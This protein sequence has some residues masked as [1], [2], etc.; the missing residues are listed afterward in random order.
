L[1]YQPG[2]A[3]A[4]RKQ[5]SQSNHRFRPIMFQEW[6]FASHEEV[7]DYIRARCDEIERVV[8]PQ[9]PVITLY[10]PQNQRDKQDIEAGMI[11]HLTSGNYQVLTPAEA[12]A[13]LNSGILY[14]RRIPIELGR[15]KP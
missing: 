12:E 13:V 5:M 8:V 9:H 2:L 6:H 7:L 11:I 10:D 4:A 14:R 3:T 15:E 1:Q